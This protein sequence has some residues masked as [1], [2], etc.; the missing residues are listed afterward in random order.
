MPAAATAFSGSILAGAAA[1]LTGTF[2]V[3]RHAVR[4]RHGRAAILAL[5]ASLLGL[6]VIA[7]TVA[8]APTTATPSRAGQGLRP[9]NIG[10]VVNTARREAEPSFTS[11]GRTMYFNCNDYDICLTHYVDAL[12]LVGA[13]TDGFGVTLFGGLGHDKVWLSHQVG[14]VWSTPADLNDVAGEP[15]VNSAFN[16]HCL[17]VSAD[18]NEAFWTSD[19]PGGF[20]GNDIR[21]SRRV[22]GKWTRPENLGGNVNGPTSDHHAMVSPD[23]R[24]LYLT[25]DRPGGLGGEDIYLTTRGPDGRWGRMVNLGPPVNGPGNDRCPVLTQDVS[26]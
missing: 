18:G 12:Y 22:V 24:S 10:P 4:S 17:F 23:G 6:S 3:L 25:S 21:T 1:A 13:I 9:V 2:A 5:G 11:D 7:T 8:W 15:P 26:P 14:G 16:N 20:G 19:R